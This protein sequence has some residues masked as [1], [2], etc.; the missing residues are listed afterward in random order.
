MT[1]VLQCQVEQSGDAATLYLSGVVRHTDHVATLV[2]LCNALPAGVR[3]LR[4]DLSAAR[5]VGADAME[6]IGVMLC[7]WRE[8]RAGDFRPLNVITMKR[9]RR[10]TYFRRSHEHASEGLGRIVYALIPDPSTSSP[11]AV[12]AVGAF[13]RGLRPA[14]E[15][16]QVV[17]DDWSIAQFWTCDVTRSQLARFESISEAD[18]LAMY[19]RLNAVVLRARESQSVGEG[20]QPA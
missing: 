10:P 5:Q 2:E 7:E 12:A 15:A 9:L 4:L 1:D 17:K 8:H 3:T 19:P 18:A 13:P 14:D 20:P 11:N 6:A 16:G